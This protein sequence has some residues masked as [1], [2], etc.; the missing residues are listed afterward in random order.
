MEEDTEQHTELYSVDIDK[1][2]CAVSGTMIVVV[3]ALA[4]ATVG[5]QGENLLIY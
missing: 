3:V 5:L 1:D 2:E 4:A